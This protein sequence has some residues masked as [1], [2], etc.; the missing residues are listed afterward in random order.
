MR[1]LPAVLLSAALLAAACGDDGGTTA[2][3]L[4]CPEPVAVT[5]AED[6][7]DQLSVLLWEGVGAYSSGVLPITSD[8]VITGTVAL[9]AS[10][11]PVTNDCL[12]R[13]DCSPQAGLIL[14]SD[15]AGAVGEG[16]ANLVCGDSYARILLTDTTVRL[17]PYL[18]DTHPCTFNFT[19]MVEVLPACGTACGEGQRMCPVDGVCYAAGAAY[20]QACEGGTKE[21]CA[22][23]G[24]D[25]TLDEGAS[26]SYWQSG[27]VRCDGTCRDG[28]CDA[29]S[30]P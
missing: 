9:D 26:C 8:L 24:P 30:C 4:E 20:C 27:D 2:P 1:R 17:R 14:N 7:V 19:P 22:C 6:L 13:S 16:D 10:A 28:A 15:V 11:L 29:G 23:Q 25:G 12:T 21:A 18:R 3:S 5:S